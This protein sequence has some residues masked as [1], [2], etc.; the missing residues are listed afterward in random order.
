[1]IVR[2]NRSQDKNGNGIWVARATVDGKRRQRTFSVD[3]SDGRSASA[4]RAALQTVDWVSGGKTRSDRRKLSLSAKVR[5]ARYANDGVTIVLAF[6]VFDDTVRFL[7][8]DAAAKDAI[9]FL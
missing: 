4:Q 5:A 9:S 3:L 8:N 1:M 6:D 2:I 7:G